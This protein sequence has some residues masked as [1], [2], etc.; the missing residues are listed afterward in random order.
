MQCVVLEPNGEAVNWDGL[1]HS[2]YANAPIALFLFYELPP[3][4]ESRI[5]LDRTA[6]G[7]GAAVPGVQ[8]A[9]SSI[10]NVAQQA[11]KL[12]DN[13]GSGSK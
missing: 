1:S 7:Q 9:C 5:A 3:P 12:D 10:A 11:A 6:S 2:L 8:L 4:Y 13:E